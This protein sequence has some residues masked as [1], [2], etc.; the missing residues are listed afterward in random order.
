M[1]RF[2]SLAGVPIGAALTVAAGS[3]TPAAGP[4]NVEVKLKANDTVQEPLP[5]VEQDRTHDESN[6]TILQPKRI[7][8]SYPLKGDE[9]R[10]K[11]IKAANSWSGSPP[12]TCSN[13]AAN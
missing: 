1:I 8:Y 4:Q 12:W 10:G 11:S 13:C 9:E 7:E 3:D 2:L 6:E 5:R